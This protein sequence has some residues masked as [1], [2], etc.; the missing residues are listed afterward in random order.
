MRITPTWAALGLATL[1]TGLMV[2]SPATADPGADRADALEALA[3]NPSA[4]RAS[5]GQAFTVRSTTKDADGTTHARI[6]RT[7]RGLEVVG[8]DLVV[9]QDASGTLEG[10]SQSLLQKLSLGV[11]PGVSSSSAERKSLAAQANEEIG[12]ASGRERVDQNG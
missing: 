9:H 1:A 4:A 7:Y 6:D 11:K 12:R 2:G 8:G 3:D 5:D 10:V